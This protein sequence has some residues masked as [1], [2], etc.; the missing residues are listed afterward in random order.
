MQFKTLLI[1]STFGL[2]IA[3]GAGTPEAIGEEKKQKK[4]FSIQTGE[5]TVT[6]G[7]D[8][9]VS[10]TIVPAKGY[11][12]NKDFPAML[13]MK[14]GTEG[15]VALKGSQYRGDDFKTGDKNVSVAAGVTGKKA[16]EQALEGEL[17]F[18]VCNEES[19]IIATEKV[20]AK[21]TVK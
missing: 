1:A 6:T 12:W 19:C 15:V 9:Q 11:K 8:G 14:E 3:L 5:T 13:T 20:E 10:I 21:V 18:S 2:I 7:K 16:G 4:T 17:R